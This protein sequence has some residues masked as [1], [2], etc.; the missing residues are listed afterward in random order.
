MFHY[1]EKKQ[2]LRLLQKV[3]Q[4]YTVIYSD[5]LKSAETFHNH[6]IVAVK[7]LEECELFLSTIANKP[8]KLL[9]EM[10]DIQLKS[11]A[12]S[13][14]VAQLEKLTKHQLGERLAKFGMVSGVGVGLVSLGPSMAVAMSTTFGSISAG[15]TLLAA[16][17][18]GLANM[19]VVVGGFGSIAAGGSFIGSRFI[20]SMLGPIGWGIS[21]I[22]LL[23]GVAKWYK[24]NKDV[25]AEAIKQADNIQ[26]NITTLKQCGY[27]V[28]EARM[29][30]DHTANKIVM[31]RIYMRKHN[32]LKDYA[33]Y[34]VEEK[35]QLGSFINLCQGLSEL[36]AKK[37]ESTVATNK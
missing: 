10:G 29:L 28:E 32:F 25:S 4:D 2:A 37:I 20:L 22:S 13:E 5:A 26:G 35:Q 24:K 8:K 23:V 33:L 14:E 18:S 11:Q 1:G 30:L 3:Q 16:T 12:F 9:Q 36:L 15:S 17:G 21:I 34:T 6:K 19:S 27:Q 31:L 7:V